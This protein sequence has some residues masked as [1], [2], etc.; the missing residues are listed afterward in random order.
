MKREHF[1]WI[2][3]VC[4]IAAALIIAYYGYWWDVAICGLGAAAS[5]WMGGYMRWQ[6]HDEDHHAP[7]A[8]WMIVAIIFL[9]LR[10]ERLA[11]QIIERRINPSFVVDKAK[12]ILN[13]AEKDKP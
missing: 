12:E 2:I 9:L 8:L 11:L 13:N 6:K 5:V 7:Q 3:A 4:Y 10:W 1:Y